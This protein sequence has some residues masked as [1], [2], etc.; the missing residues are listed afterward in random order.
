VMFR[1][2]LTRRSSLPNDAASN[3]LWPSRALSSDPRRRSYEEGP[4]LALKPKPSRLLPLST[5]KAPAVLPTVPASGIAAPT[6]GVTR[7]KVAVKP[8]VPT[9]VVYKAKYDRG[10]VLMLYDFFQD[11]KDGWSNFERDEL[12]RAGGLPD[13]VRRALQSLMQAGPMRFKRL[14]VAMFPNASP[15]D[16]AA[17]T[18]LVQQERHTAKPVPKEKPSEQALAELDSQQRLELT[19]MFHQIDIDN[20]GEIDLDELWQSMK[21]LGMSKPEVV[22]VFNRIDINGDGAISCEEY[23]YGLQSIFF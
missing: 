21:V 17:M 19:T 3:Q 13:P 12:Y 22:E 20:S 15:I 2:R 9:K 4:N 11:L 16:F 18:L 14:L 23:V 5:G 6:I 10:L 7:P 8:A 1:K